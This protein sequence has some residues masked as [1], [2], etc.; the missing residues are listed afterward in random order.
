MTLKDSSLKSMSVM[1]S[2]E[3]FGRE[4]CRSSQIFSGGSRQ[5]AEFAAKKESTNHPDLPRHIG[6]HIRAGFSDDHIIFNAHAVSSGQIDSRFNGECHAGFEQLHI[7]ATHVGFLVAFHADAMTG[8][9]SEIL[10]VTCLF[11]HI[12]R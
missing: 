2:P 8:A 9:M 7:I 4:L 10:A 1:V 11:D 3:M 6:E 5:F 12:S